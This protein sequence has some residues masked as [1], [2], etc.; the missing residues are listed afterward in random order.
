[1]LPLVFIFTIWSRNLMTSVVCSICLLAILTLV[2]HSIK[3]SK[4][5]SN[6]VHIELDGSEQTLRLDIFDII[7]NIYHYN[8]YLCTSI[9]ILAVDFNV[10]PLYFSKTKNY[11]Q[12]IMDLGVSFFVICH[13]FKS[14]KRFMQTDTKSIRT[15]KLFT[16]SLRRG[17]ALAVLGAFRLAM[18]ILKRTNIDSSYGKHWNFFFTLSVMQ[19]ILSK[20]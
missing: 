20:A 3:N 2:I 14:V 13:S 9:C 12:S 6:L 8:V 5:E 15:R 16:D 7:T 18:T 17:I 10:F 11:G 1:M 4:D 19:V